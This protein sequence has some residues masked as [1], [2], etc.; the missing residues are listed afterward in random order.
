M[1]RESIHINMRTSSSNDSKY[2]IPKLSPIDLAFFRIGGPGLG[3]L[4]F[5]ITRAFVDAKKNNGV[6]IN[7][8]FPQVKLGPLLRMEKDKRFYGK[9]FAS[10]YW[11]NRIHKIFLMSCRSITEE[12]ST[13]DDDSVVIYFSGLGTYFYP[14]VGWEDAIR[15]FLYEEN[16]FSLE[17]NLRNGV[18]VH[19]RLGDFEAARKYMDGA[20][21]TQ[22]SVDWY[23]AAIGK[24]KSLLGSAVK[25]TLFSDDPIRAKQLFP[26][27]CVWESSANALSEMLTMSQYESLV[28]ANSTFSLWASFLSNGTSIWHKNF[29]LERYRPREVTDHTV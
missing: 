26:D 10:L 7:G 3:N 28:G 8:T 24:S 2:Y 25:V 19:L 21:N 11:K 18:A 16:Y 27:L 9:E 20:A 15:E 12:K 17:R 14:L 4:L 6:F 13:A 29:D 1:G 5:P 22:N 23:R